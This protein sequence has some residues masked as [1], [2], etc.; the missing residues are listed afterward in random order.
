[1]Q[2]LLLFATTG[3]LA[4]GQV[5]FKVTAGHD[6]SDTWAFLFSPIFLAALV[7]YGVATLCWILALRQFPLTVAYPMQALAIV[8]VLIIGV[9][10]FKENLRPLQWA[11]AAAILAGLVTLAL[12]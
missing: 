7:V 2:Y 1:M 4:L 5:L 9:M 10:V 11:G 3:L 6:P 8:I 12:G